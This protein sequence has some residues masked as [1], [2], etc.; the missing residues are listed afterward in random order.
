[1]QTVQMDARMFARPARLSGVW[2]GLPGKE[3]GHRPGLV[4]L[5]LVRIRRPRQRRA[6]RSISSMWLRDCEVRGISGKI[7]EFS[8]TLNIT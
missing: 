1:M 5:C 7:G 8:S 4:R 2:R 3:T 6:P